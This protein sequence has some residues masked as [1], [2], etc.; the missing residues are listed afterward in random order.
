VHQARERRSKL[1]SDNASP[2][3]PLRK[4]RYPATKRLPRHARETFERGSSPRHRPAAS[5]IV[6][7]IDTSWPPRNPTILRIAFAGSR[8]ATAEHAQIPSRRLNSSDN[9]PNSIPPATPWWA[10]SPSHNLLDWLDPY[11]P[12]HPRHSNPHSVWR[13]ISPNI[14]RFPPLEVC[15]RRPRRARHHLHGAGIRKTSQHRTL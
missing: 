13:L 12:G 14:P 8:P 3:S 10:V 7:R 4:F 5:P 6:I 9:L 15:V 2:R 11:Q 1:V